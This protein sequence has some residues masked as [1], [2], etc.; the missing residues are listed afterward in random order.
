[1][2][3]KTVKVKDIFEF[4]P[5]N[6]GLTRKEVILKKSEKLIPVY[7]ASKDKDFVF[8]WVEKTSKWTKYENALT[9]NTDGVYAGCVFYRKNMFVPYEKIKVLKIKEE[10]IK[11]LDYDYLRIVLELKFRSMGFGFGLKCSMGRVKPIEIKIPIITK[12]EFDIEAQ[13]KFVIRYNKFQGAKEQLQY[14]STQ[15]SDTKLDFNTSFSNKEFTIKDLFNVKKGNSKYTRRYINSNKGDF[16]VYSSQTTDEGII[17]KINSY[18]FDECCLTWTTDGIYAGTVFVRNG[19]FNMTTHCGAL[20]LKEEH[21]DKI[22]LTFVYQQLNT[23]LKLYAIGE[24]N[25]RITVDMIKKVTL[26]IPFKEGKIDLQKQKEISARHEKAEEV[27][28]NVL[29]D[30]DTVLALEITI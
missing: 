24:G 11:D 10:Y 7:S 20:I 1:M 23:T 21:K 28:L 2:K 17:G 3:Y 30:L 8:G 27:R 4:P 6:S 18:D 13:K 9:W 5:S 22:D 15:L 16:P 25:K 12:D 14:L 29:E 19:K 26:L